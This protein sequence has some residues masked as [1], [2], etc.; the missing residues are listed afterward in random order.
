MPSKDELTTFSL[1][2]ETIVKQKNIPYMDAVIMYCEE[3]G[4]EL[5]VAGKLV[6][7]ALKSKIKIEAEDLN[8]LPKSNTAKL[9]F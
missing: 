9:P 8:F 2:I 7:G 5:E 6:T 3:T 1:E 4:L